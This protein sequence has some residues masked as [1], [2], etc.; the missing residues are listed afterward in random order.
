MKETGAGGE[1]PGWGS[2]FG[3]TGPR[4]WPEIAR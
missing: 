3:K 1:R 4:S 2:P